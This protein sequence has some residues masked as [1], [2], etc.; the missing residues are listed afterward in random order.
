M[1]KTWMQMRFV[2][3]AAIMGAVLGGGTAQ[4]APLTLNNP[5]F[6]DDSLPTDYPDPSSYRIGALGW[7]YHPSYAYIWNPS[8]TYYSNATGAGVPPGG[9]GPKSAIVYSGGWFYQ[10]VPAQT[11][12]EGTYTLT[13]AV[14]Q[15]VG[16]G[17]ANWYID[18]RTD[19][20]N[21][22]SGVDDTALASQSGASP[23]APNG[24]FVDA[25]S[26][27]YTVLS[28]NPYIGRPI[29]VTLYSASNS[30]FDNVRLDFATAGTTT[31]STTTTSTTSSTSSD[32]SSTSTTTTSTSSST[33]TTAPAPHATSGI[34]DEFALPGTAAGVTANGTLT[35]VGVDDT[36]PWQRRYLM[37]TQHGGTWSNFRSG[38]GELWSDNYGG[39]STYSVTYGVLAGASAIGDLASVAT[40]FRTTLS[41]LY[42]LRGKGILT[43]TVWDTDSNASVSINDVP[44]GANDMLFAAF[45]GIDFTDVQSVQVSLYAYNSPDYSNFSIDRFETFSAVNNPPV[46]DAGPSAT[47]NPTV[48]LTTALSVQASDPDL[49]TL[50]YTWSKVSGPA[51]TVN[52]SPNGTQASSS[53][54]ATFP[55]AGSYTL[56]V[57][58]SDGALT[59]NKTVDVT[60]NAPVS[61]GGFVDE[62]DL[63]ASPAAVTAGGSLTQVPVDA[64]V[65]SLQRRVVHTVNNGSIYTLSS[66]GGDVSGYNS[67]GSSAWTVQ[68]GVLAGVAAIGNLQRFGNAFEVEL[69][70]TG[71]TGNLI[72]T[73]YDGGGG[74]LTASL[75]DV[76]TGTSTLDFSQFTGSGT[77]M[78][79]A[80]IQVQL[81]A[82]FATTSAQ[83]D[84]ERVEI[85]G[86]PFL[87]SVLKFK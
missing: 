77:L 68:Y 27:V 57:A 54:T 35:Q 71:G 84:I 65:P 80:S 12:Q 8:S 78:N 72:I 7:Q 45:A 62:F 39:A 17:N 76:G 63:P 55:S 43:V 52:F 67:N 41:N 19:A 36:V 82:S 73:L 44:D 33:S 61:T 47:P 30:E 25:P 5:S 9:D 23:G 20:N 15:R 46:I 28:G 58:V 34:L 50:Y 70:K 66:G 4:A 49:Q 53:S 69:T 59:A 31:S 56:N 87:G 79:V 51:G 1:K 60:V 37:H 18:F 83:F 74:T 64:D 75:S 22:G 42:P 16:G 81:D 14:G 24:E 29:G 86:V 13:V 38:G 32:S 48:S 21:N 85:V 6:E 26:V 2:V 11:L 40:G 3:L 10:D